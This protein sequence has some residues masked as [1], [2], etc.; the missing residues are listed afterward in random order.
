MQS[1]R[2]Y[3]SVRTYCL[4]STVTRCR[5]M[6]DIK[7]VRARMC[8]SV[9][10][11]QQWLRITFS[12]AAEMVHSSRGAGATTSCTACVT[13]GIRYSTTRKT[14]ILIMAGAATNCGH[15]RGSE[16]GKEL[17]ALARGS[18]VGDDHPRS[19]AAM[20]LALVLGLDLARMVVPPLTAPSWRTG[21]A[22]T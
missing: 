19:C 16:G 7:S 20:R 1:R 2:H 18:A 5:H 3:L 22:A 9:H 17:P 8:S 12:S 4:L 15:A 21:R 6:Y 10:I 13:P 11:Y 14:A